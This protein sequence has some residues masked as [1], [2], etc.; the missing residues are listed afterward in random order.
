MNKTLETNQAKQALLI[1]LKRRN[2]KLLKKIQL[3]LKLVCLQD[4]QKKSKYFWK[5]MIL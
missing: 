2:L 3:V 5:K 1:R 4:V